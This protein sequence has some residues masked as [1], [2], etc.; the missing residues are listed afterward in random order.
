MLLLT[1][2]YVTITNINFNFNVNIPS[3]ACSPFSK[4]GLYVCLKTWQGFS[5][6]SLVLGLERGA[7]PC[8][9]HEVWR[10]VPNKEKIETGEEEE[11]EKGTLEPDT[12]LA[13][14]V[15]GGFQSADQQFRIVKEHWIVILDRDIKET[16]R[17]RCFS[18]H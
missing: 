6:D 13:I 16:L 8:F 11:E 1:A 2:F 17:F 4:D 7:G 3:F 15:E 14:G 18:H 9:L 5:R 12:K 10:R